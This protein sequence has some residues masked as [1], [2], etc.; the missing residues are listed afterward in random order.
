MQAQP[1]LALEGVSKTFRRSGGA[2]VNAVRAVSLEVGLG[3]TVALV[4]E[5]GSGKST[6]G[7]MALGLLQPE[8]GRV[9][10][11][12]R[13]LGSMSGAELR[14]ERIAVQPIFQDAAASLNPRR[15]V[16][17]LLAQALLAKQP[18]PGRDAVEARS[19]EL[20]ESVGLRPGREYLRRY[21]HEL[22]G[23]QRQRL[24]IARALAMEPRLI[25]ADEPLSGAD[26]SIRG[27]ILNLL[28]DI[29][30]RRGVAYLMITHDISIARAFADRVAV[31]MQGEI[32]EQG[33]ARQVLTSPAQDYTKRL[34]A[35]VP[36]LELPGSPI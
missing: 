2:V 35:A 22:S 33:P 17:E 15:Q 31:M 5:S 30:E 29:K 12:G 7:R 27:Q 1:L 6:L 3:E 18:G 13:D 19:I 25:V 8:A 4:G 20:V 24:A 14:R 34:V 23:G 28:I 36:V 9:L 21:P 10:L 26:V 16:L 11:D 32:V